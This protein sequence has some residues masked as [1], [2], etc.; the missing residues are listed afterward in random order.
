MKEYKIQNWSQKISHSCLLLKDQVSDDPCWKKAS[1][2]FRKA[3]G[4]GSARSLNKDPQFS[5]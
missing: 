1:K 5:T 3:F 4:L 2:V